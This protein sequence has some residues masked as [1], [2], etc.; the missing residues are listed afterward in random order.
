MNYLRLGPALGFE[1]FLRKSNVLRAFIFLFFDACVNGI[2]LLKISVI[3]SFVTVNSLAIPHTC[4]NADF[5]VLFFS[6]LSKLYLSWVFNGWHY[7]LL[8]VYY[9]LEISP[10]IRVSTNY[11]YEDV[12]ID[13]YPTRIIASLLIPLPAFSNAVDFHILLIP[14]K[15]P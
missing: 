15:S 1:I 5:F 7:S 6:S 10:I 2:L 8:L 3:L 9:L 12:G 11:F 4:P 14:M 13:L